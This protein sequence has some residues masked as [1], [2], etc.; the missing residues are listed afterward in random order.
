MIEPK[1]LTRALI[2]GA[3]GLGLGFLGWWLAPSLKFFASLIGTPLLY[4]SW[5]IAN[6]G[7]DDTISEGHWFLAKRPLFPWAYGALSCYLV[8]SF[9][10]LL[11]SGAPLEAVL[12]ALILLLV[13]IGLQSHFF[14]QSQ[15]VYDRL[16]GVRRD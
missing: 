9:T 13:W 14:F 10:E 8:I 5:A 2:C 1:N 11:K 6:K 12:K 15:D 7:E 3:A 4:E 16:W